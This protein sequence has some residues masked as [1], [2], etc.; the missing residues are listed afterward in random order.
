MH[1]PTEWYTLEKHVSSS[2]VEIMEESSV[3]ERKTFSSGRTSRKSILLEI[4][5]LSPIGIATSLRG[6]GWNVSPCK[7]S[8]LFRTSHFVYRVPSITCLRGRLSVDK[9]YKSSACS[10]CRSASRNRRTDCHVSLFAFL[11]SCWTPPSAG[12][13]E[14]SKCTRAVSAESLAIL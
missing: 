14:T 2:Q 4:A 7:V 6:F 8:M 5:F 9:T 13:E 1:C 11:V 3:R 10:L 12:T